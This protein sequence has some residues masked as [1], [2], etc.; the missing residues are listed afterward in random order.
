M[1]IKMN[2]KLSRPLSTFSIIL[3][4]LIFSAISLGKAPDKSKSKSLITILRDSKG[5]ELGTAELSPISNG[6][7][8]KLDLKG[9]PPGKHGFHFHEKGL[10]E[11]PDFKTAGNHFNP[12]R[13]EHGT[14]NEKGPH[15]GDLPNIEANS[16]GRIQAEFVS[17]SA[18]LDQ[19]NKTL[20]QKGG[21][22]LILH[23]KEDDLKS[24]PSG[25]SGAR[26]ACGVIKK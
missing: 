12:E 3:L 6:V 20:L 19:S 14:H 22:S 15:V 11:T 25:N 23:E 8:I 9:V 2:R 7:K 5:N 13:K 16:E 10:C 4:S 26:I 17:L 21:T 24:D 18:T 1:T